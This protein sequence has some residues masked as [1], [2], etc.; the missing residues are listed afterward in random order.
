M[1]EAVQSRVHAH[2]QATEKYNEELK[3]YTDAEAAATTV[4]PVNEVAVAVGGPAATVQPAQ[5]PYATPPTTRGQL[6]CALIWH[7]SKLAQ[8]YNPDASRMCP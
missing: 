1:C 3:A 5:V 4:T 2:R 7:L 8:H 6:F